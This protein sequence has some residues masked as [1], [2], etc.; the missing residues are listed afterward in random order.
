MKPKQQY[1][2]TTTYLLYGSGPSPSV[3]GGSQKSKPEPGQK[4]RQALE[5]KQGDLGLKRYLELDFHP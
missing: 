5:A 1:H 4:F 2:A 3:G